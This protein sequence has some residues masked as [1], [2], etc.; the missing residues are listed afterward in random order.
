MDHES[1][2]Q[3]P[4][5]LG[6]PKQ[7]VPASWAPKQDASP[8]EHGL[9]G[10]HHVSGYLTSTNPTTQ[11]GSKMGGEF[12]YPEMVP[13]VLTHGPFWKQVPSAHH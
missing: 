4:Q 10:L 1:G 8:F 5:A 9:H 2:S 11:I 7:A 6:A 12:T 3:A 13:L